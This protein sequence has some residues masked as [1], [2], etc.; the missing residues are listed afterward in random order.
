MDLADSWEGLELLRRSVAMLG[1]GTPAL[2][3]EQAL[4]LLA[5]VQRL[6]TELTWFEHGLRRLLD[7]RPGPERSP[8]RPPG[9]RADGATRGP[10]G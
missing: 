9:A 6:R 1:P 10:V 5:E 7:E 3:R 8:H 4:S 2:D